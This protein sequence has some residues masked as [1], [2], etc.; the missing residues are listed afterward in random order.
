MESKKIMKNSR[1][2]KT[3]ANEEENKIGQ[4]ERL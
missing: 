4:A 1:R 3:W 2:G